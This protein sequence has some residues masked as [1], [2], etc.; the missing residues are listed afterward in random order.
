LDHL[1]VEFLYS[2]QS[3]VARNVVESKLGE[4]NSICGADVSY[5]RGEAFGVAVKEEGERREINRV[6]AKVE[7]PYVPGLLF[8]RE[9]PVVIHL[10]KDVGCDLTFI[11]GHGLA[12][13]RFAGLATVVG[14]LLGRPT[15]GVAKS[16]LVGELVEEG[17]T[18]FLEVKGRR[19]G[20]KR[21]R[22]YYSIGNMVTL[23]D[24]IK[25]SFTYPSVLAIAD[26][27]TKR[28]RREGQQELPKGEESG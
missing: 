19:V 4:V 11:D 15:I 12:H 23:K 6:K 17:E 3:L 9:A 24:V 1:T 22:Y 7:F 8:V 5:W 16:R 10:L 26:Q 21:G 18:T 28:F 27:E 25:F 20:V 13:P 14:V 2:I